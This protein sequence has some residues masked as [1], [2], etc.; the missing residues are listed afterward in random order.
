MIAAAPWFRRSGTGFAASIAVLLGACSLP[1]QTPVRP[2]AV[3]S[4]SGCVIPRVVDGDTIKVSCAGQ[5][6]SARLVGFDTPEITK[7]RCAAEAR[8]GQ[9][10]SDFLEQTLRDSKVVEAVPVNRREKFGRTLIRLKIDGRDISQTMVSAG[11]AVYYKG[12]KR[13]NWCERLAA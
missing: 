8:L 10:A 12:G 4:T 3:I 5:S 9:T 13:I 11:L 1:E 7:P 2:L 6:V